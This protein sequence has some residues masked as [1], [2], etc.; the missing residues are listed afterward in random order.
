MHFQKNHHFTKGFVYDMV[1]KKEVLPMKFKVAIIGLLTAILAVCCFT[2][3]KLIQET[4]RE[5]KALIAITEGLIEIDNSS[6]W[7]G[8]NEA[9]QILMGYTK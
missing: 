3:I 2:S 7:K 4:E 8:F 5:K 1:R 9:W 6:G